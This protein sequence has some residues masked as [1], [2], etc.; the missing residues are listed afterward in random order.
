MT[1]SVGRGQPTKQ[2]NPSFKATKHIEHSFLISDYYLSELLVGTIELLIG[3][4]L[5]SRSS[6]TQ[7]R[8]LHEQLI[9]CYLFQSKTR[10]TVWLLWIITRL[11]AWW[12]IPFCSAS[13]KPTILIKNNALL[14]FKSY[15]SDW[16]QLVLFMR[17][18]SFATSV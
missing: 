10:L 5:G 3:S 6:T 9:L 4:S 14:L 16:T 12:I 2:A 18:S 13:L 11:L 15:L 17:Q 1:M 8:R 7:R